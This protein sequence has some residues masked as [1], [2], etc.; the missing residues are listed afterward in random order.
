MQMKKLI[1]AVGIVCLLA[2]CANQAAPNKGTG[3]QA[4][5]QQATQKQ[6]AQKPGAQTKQGTQTKATQHPGGGHDHITV[7]PS[8]DRDKKL[9][10]NRYDSTN[11]G[12]G[13]ATYS[14]MGSSSLL[15][16]GPSSNLESQLAAAGVHGVKA[17]VMDDCVFVAPADGKTLSVNHMDE[18]QSHLL[19][20]YQGSSARGKQPGDKV[21]TLGTSDQAG[22]M[23]RAHDQI[24]RIY[25]GRV[26]IRT[27]TN[28]DAVAAMERIRQSLSKH[29]PQA[30]TM[31]KT[32]L[33]SDLSL[34][35]RSAST[36]K[37]P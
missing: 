12:M 9:T 20:G 35:L 23:A 34:L 14:M 17:L 5:R 3:N 7:I 32:N 8:V 31:Q 11:S 18:T 25:G 27:V 22:L 15:D 36:S 2:A 30:A 28:P 19:S 16:G 21:G 4:A 33:A 1:S 24:E 37:Q 10:T 13:T 29:H 6:T 26:Q